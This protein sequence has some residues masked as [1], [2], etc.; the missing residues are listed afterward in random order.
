ML[1]AHPEHLFERRETGSFTRTNAN[2]RLQSWQARGPQFARNASVDFGGELAQHGN[3]IAGLKAVSRDECLAAHLVEGIVE[4]RET[5]GRID[6]D[7]NCTRFCRRE[8]S[9]NPL[10]IVGRPDADAITRLDPKGEK[11]GREGIDASLK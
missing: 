7:E 8:L 10:G 5:V 1:T 4:L 11:P 6:V 2:Q 9:N 3:V